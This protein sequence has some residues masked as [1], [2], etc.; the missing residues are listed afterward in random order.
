VVDVAAIILQERQRDGIC[1]ENEKNN[2][3]ESDL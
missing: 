2:V 3:K 1:E